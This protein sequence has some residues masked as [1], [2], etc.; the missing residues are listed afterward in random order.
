MV[1][2]MLELGFRRIELSHGIRISLVAG[3][4]KA[5]E[6]GIVEISS[7]HNFCPLP[8]MVQHAAPN[9]YEPSSA[10]PRELDLW[11]RY[12][13]QTIDFASKVGAPRIVVHSGSLHYFFR[14]PE[15]RLEKWIDKSGLEPGDLTGNKDFI[16]RRDRAMKRIRR[17]APPW[18][19]RTGES[20]RQLF[21]AVRERGLILGVENREGLEEIP[22]DDEMWHFLESLGGDA[23]VGY[24]H[25][26]GHAQLKEQLGLLDHAAHL[27][28]PRAETDRFP[29]A[30]CVG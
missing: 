26:C 5:V 27:A 29:P 7:V 10:D 16:K 14:S 8:N 22:L 3:I 9:L 23:P 13:L 30:R 1:V 17:D 6:E 21:E 25:D 20:Y 11:Q 15:A 2:E 18:L 24:W 28:Q 12:T 4:L 19:E